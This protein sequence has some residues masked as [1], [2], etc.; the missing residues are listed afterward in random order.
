MS[1]Y[2]CLTCGAR[3]SMMGHGNRHSDQTLAIVDKLVGQG[4][5]RSKAVEAV[6]MWQI[7]EAQLPPDK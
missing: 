2:W 6:G 1:D 5:L 4:V 7:G 3:T